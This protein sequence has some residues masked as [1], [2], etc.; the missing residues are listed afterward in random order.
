MRRVPWVAV[1][2]FLFASPSIGYAGFNLLKKVE[3]QVERRVD[4]EVDQS[5]DQGLDEAEKAVKGE[6]DESAG[7][8]SR[9]QT[10]SAGQARELEGGSSPGTTRQQLKAW[11]KYDFVPGDEIIFLDDLK[12]EESGEFPSRWD[13]STGNVEIAEF[14]D[15]N[16]INFATVRPCE[17]VPLMT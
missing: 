7:E 10:K 14:G 17:I 3:E 15:E 13:L 16:V 4:H 1:A 2:V 11:S 9:P 6:G 5:I 8:G 12:D